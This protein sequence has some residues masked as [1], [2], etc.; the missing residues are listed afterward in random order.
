MKIIEYLKKPP[1]NLVLVTST[2]CDVE[3]WSCPA[4][5]HDPETQTSGLMSVEM[6]DKIIRKVKPE[7][8]LINVCGYYFNEITIVPQIVEMIKCV[9]SHGLP[10]LLSSNLVRVKP[11]V[12]KAIMD[13]G[14]SNFIISMS[15]WT[16]EVYERSHKNGDIERVKANMELMA[17][18]RKPGT[19]IRCAFHR[20]KYNEK[21]EPLMEAYCKKLGFDWTPYNIGLLPLDAVFKAWDTGIYPP[22]TVDLQTSL[23]D[24]KGMCLD[25]KHW[26]CKMQDQFLT[27]D[28]NGNYYNCSDRIGQHNIRGSLF[29]TT[30]PE[31]FHKRQTDSACVKCK[32][33]GG[34][35]YAAQAYTRSEWSPV[36]IG[37]EVYHELGLPGLAPQLSKWAITKFYRRPNKVAV[38][39]L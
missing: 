31:I 35:V 32:A 26:I 27:V 39:K 8:R 24:A 12:L 25:R 14:I 29:S 9:H 18:W 10:F 36:R 20:Y 21:E 1:C 19:F 11:D 33:V 2:K 28:A 3:C 17:Q 23:K 6:L 5:R 34:H 7:T 16:Q 38:G 22:K 4:G 13:T 37:E 30:V 15:G